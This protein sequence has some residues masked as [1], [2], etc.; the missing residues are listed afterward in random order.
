[1][2]PP[3]NPY[4][5]PNYDAA[6]L[7]HAEAIRTDPQRVAGAALAA[8]GQVK[9]KAAEA[10]AMARVA[11]G[12]MGGTPPSSVPPPHTHQ[13]G[14]PIATAESGMNVTRTTR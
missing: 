5:D 9:T 6:V 4:V 3:T 12:G 13:T 1:M 2:A 7:A 14:T 10:E 11:A 8:E